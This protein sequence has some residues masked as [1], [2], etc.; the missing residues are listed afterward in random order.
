VSF[1]VF[2]AVGSSVMNASPTSDLNP[3][4]LAAGCWLTLASHGNMFSFFYHTG[5]NNM[6]KTVTVN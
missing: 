6:M 2:Q 5:R 1:C 3:L 4:L